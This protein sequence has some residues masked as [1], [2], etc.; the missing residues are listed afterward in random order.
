M[1]RSDLGSGSHSLHDH[2][3]T[4]VARQ[5]DR[6]TTFVYIFV[7]SGRAPLTQAAI[8]AVSQWQY[9]PYLLNGTPVEIETQITVQFKLH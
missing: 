2:A 9:R 3:A 8:D 7:V 4:G 5:S 6:S 1:R